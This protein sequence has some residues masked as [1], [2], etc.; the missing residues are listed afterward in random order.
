VEELFTNMVKYSPGGE[1]EV[2]IDMAA[3]AGGVE[4]TLTDHGVAPFDITRSPEA[5]IH[6]PIGQREAGGLGLHLVRKL[7]DSLEY[8]YEEGARRSRIKFRKTLAGKHSG[9]DEV[10]PGGEDARD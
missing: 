8:D 6:L 2:R 9:G 4:V 1:A 5:D 3:I 7:V 10:Q